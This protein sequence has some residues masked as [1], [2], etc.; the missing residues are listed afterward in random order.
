ML[1]F[2]FMAWDADLKKLQQ[3]V[4]DLGCEAILGNI[5]KILETQFNPVYFNGS[6]NSSFPLNP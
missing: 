2:V 3:Q 6:F 4:K 5:T 1:I